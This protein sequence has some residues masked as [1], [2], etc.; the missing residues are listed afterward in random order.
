MTL[1]QL[2]EME[3]GYSESKIQHICVNWFRDTFPIAAN[4][5]FAVPNGGY[6]GAKAALVMRYEGQTN[7]V[8]DL[9][10]LYPSGG[11]C[12]LCIEMKVPKRKGSSAGRQSDAQKAWQT[13][14]ERYGSRY[15][16][17]HGLEEFITAV[18]EYLDFDVGEY[19]DDALRKYPRYR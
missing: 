4:L 9:I 6:R 2:K 19:L 15:V 3:Q 16:I 18:C 14:V 10:F 12:S 8:A 17:C 13:L 11:K 1:Q 7:G 5:L